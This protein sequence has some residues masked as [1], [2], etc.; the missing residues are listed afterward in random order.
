MMWFKLVIHVTNVWRVRLPPKP[1]NLRQN[2]KMSGVKFQFPVR[3]PI[4][5]FWV[6]G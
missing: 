4:F 1:Q 2:P 5:E 3:I 6:S